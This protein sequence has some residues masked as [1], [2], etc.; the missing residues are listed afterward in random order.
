M[1][2]LPRPATAR[3]ELK[4]AG[5]NALT[6]IHKHKMQNLGRPH[7]VMTALGPG[8]SLVLATEVTRLPYV[9]SASSSEIELRSSQQAIRRGLMSMKYSTFALIYMSMNTLTSHCIASHRTQCSPI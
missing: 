2:G 5:M 8:K 6:K 7:A 1:C 9:F 3:T 4:F